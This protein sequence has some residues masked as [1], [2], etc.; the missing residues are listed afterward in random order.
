MSIRALSTP[1]P[2]TIKN[3]VTRLDDLHDDVDVIAFR[4]CALIE[5][6]RA[7]L[8]SRGVFFLHRTKSHVR[9]WS[10]ITGP[11]DLLQI[12]RVDPPRRR[13]GDD[14]HHPATPRDER[15]DRPTFACRSA[16]SR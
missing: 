7:R 10:G 1:N 3:A 8:G 13:P 14:V 5:S 16:R 15:S 6:G 12:S 9:H 11:S 4:Q 2:Q